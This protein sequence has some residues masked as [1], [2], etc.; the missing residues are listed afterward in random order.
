MAA[1]IFSLM[2]TLG[3]IAMSA[4]FVAGC[5]DDASSPAFTPETLTFSAEAPLDDS[6][7]AIQTV[8]LD[9]QRSRVDWRIEHLGLTD[10]QWAT[11]QDIRNHH[12]PGP[13]SGSPGDRFTELLGEVGADAEQIDA[14]LQDPLSADQCV[15]LPELLP[16]RPHREPPGGRG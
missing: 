7:R 4:A 15:D 3:V 1:R 5:G 14:A 10:E 8:S 9:A 16:D 2:I 11:L 13:G 6:L 12:G